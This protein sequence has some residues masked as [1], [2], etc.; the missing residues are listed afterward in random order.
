[1]PAPDKV[2]IAHSTGGTATMTWGFT[3]TPQQKIKLA[4]IEGKFSN[5]N[6]FKTLVPAGSEG[7]LPFDGSAE[8]TVPNVEGEWDVTVR[9]KAKSGH[10]GEEITVKCVV[11]KTQPEIS[12]LQSVSYTHL[13]VIVSGYSGGDIV[14]EQLIS[15]LNTVSY[16]HLNATD[17]RKST[18]N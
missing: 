6:S 15:G 12:G 18:P 14:A 8:I 3:Y 17:T 11:D 10:T 5:E 1:M 9:G 13:G 4:S 7:T 16:T 2:Q